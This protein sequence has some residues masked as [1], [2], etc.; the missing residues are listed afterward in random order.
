MEPMNC[1][2]CGRIFVKIK[3]AICN[4]CVKAEEDIYEAVRTYVKENPNQTIK[5]ISDACDVSVK[6][7]LT[8]LQDGKLEA[9]EGLQSESICSKCGRPIRTGRMCETCILQVNFQVGDMKEQAKIKNKGKMHS[10]GSVI[11]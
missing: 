2:R 8:Y 6:R 7:I 5:E 9:S 4:A 3:D 11:Q 1:P 10:G